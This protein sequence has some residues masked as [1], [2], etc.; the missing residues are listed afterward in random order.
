[1]VILEECIENSLSQAPNLVL[2]WRLGTPKL[3]KVEVK[4]LIGYLNALHINAGR[5]DSL[6]I[7]TEKTNVLGSVF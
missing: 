5:T 4:A 2:A 1:M 6:Q 7:L 3:S